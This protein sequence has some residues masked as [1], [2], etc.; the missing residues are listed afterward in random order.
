[1]TE[2]ARPTAPLPPPT[3]GQPA[4]K[5]PTAAARYRA[6]R[7]RVQLLALLVWGG[8]AVV[9]ALAGLMAAGSKDVPSE[10]FWIAL[11][12]LWLLYL[13][14]KGERRRL[15]FPWI[16]PRQLGAGL[17]RVGLV[18][19]GLTIAVGAIATN[20]G[21]NHLFGVFGLMLSLILASGILAR[22]NLGRVLVKRSVPDEI[23][24]GAP[25]PITIAATNRGLF[26]SMAVWVS[27]GWPVD[28]EP[29]EGGLPSVCVVRLDP[30]D[31]A[32]ATYEIAFP[33]RGVFRF[34]GFVLRTTFPFSMFTNVRHV[35]QEQEVLVLPRLRRLRESMRPRGDALNASGL[36][37][38]PT[39]R[40]AGDFR[41]LRDYAPGLDEVRWIHWP[42]SA[43]RFHTGDGETMAPV[44][45]DFERETEGPRVIVL[46]LGERGAVLEAG[47]ELAAAFLVDSFE[48]GLPFTIV[49]P[50]TTSAGPPSRENV[51]RLRCLE[52][53]ARLHGRERNA[54]VDLDV[55][56]A[57]TLAEL[58]EMPVPAGASVVAL[59][60]E[61][62][63]RFLDWVGAHAPRG[64]RL[65]RIAVA[66]RARSGTRKREIAEIATASLGT[67]APYAAVDTEADATPTLFGPDVSVASVTESGRL[68]VA[69]TPDGKAENA[70][71]IEPRASLDSV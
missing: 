56:T 9:V 12:L 62:D 63:H 32:E 44:V 66:P 57:P 37:A 71:A 35:R 14:L 53:L 20:T 27:E 18:H 48:A 68:L 1:M 41:G 58:I 23:V 67:K 15:F 30:N 47:I 40:G 54:A 5:T 6:L 24:A 69:Q 49:V 16:S 70:P 52:I 36:R 55:M 2:P 8:I 46:E 60:T 33:H 28:V 59:E 7:T 17:T 51:H 22:H 19:I 25:T 45:R 31:V 4:A 64:S 13:T 10:A 65:E 39:G 21:N 50:P 42:T 26:P 61:R 29:P 11:V 34:Q 3:A 43:R 38:E